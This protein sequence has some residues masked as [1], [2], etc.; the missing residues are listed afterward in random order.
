MIDA[1]AGFA[2]SGVLDDA[3]AWRCLR[4]VAPC[5]R[6]SVLIAV[7]HVAYATCGMEI[8]SFSFACLARCL[9]RSYGNGA[10]MSCRALFLASIKV[11]GSVL[12]LMASSKLQVAR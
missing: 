1:S 3:Y 6:S 9:A 5:P 12:L 10:V 8:C 4:C 11:V 7:F 2:I